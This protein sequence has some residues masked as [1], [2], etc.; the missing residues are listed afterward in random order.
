MNRYASLIVGILLIVFGGLF[1]AVNLFGR[2]LGF[3]FLPFSIWRMWPA[4][5]LILGA[6]FASVPVFFPGQRW[7]GVFFIPASIFLTTGSILMFSSVFEAWGIWNWAWALLLPALA[8]GFLLAAAFMRNG[9]IAIPAFP[10]GVT[11]VILLFCA[12]TNM[13]NIWTWA[14]TLEIIGVGLMIAF[15]G[16]LARSTATLIVGV[17]LAGAGLSLTS[18]M[19]SIFSFSMEAGGIIASALLMI[20]GII[21]LAYSFFSRNKTAISSPPA[22]S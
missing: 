15:I 14:W 10:I 20:L 12:V 7:S 21:I 1:L 5:V 8:A 11:G 9:Y 2:Y 13:W 17:C 19:L 22:A 18:I 16:R 3:P 6:A 4:V